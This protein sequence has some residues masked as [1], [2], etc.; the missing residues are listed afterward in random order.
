MMYLKF[1][2]CIVS[3]NKASSSY[4]A[5]VIKIKSFVYNKRQFSKKC[6]WSFKDQRI[7]MLNEYL[8]NKKVNK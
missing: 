6:F 8:A 1:V 5:F 7:K 4:M 2:V 3:Q